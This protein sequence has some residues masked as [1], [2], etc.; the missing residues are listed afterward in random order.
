VSDYNAVES[1]FST[2]D[3]GTALSL[4]GW[5]AA[6]GQDQHSILLADAAA[7]SALFVNRAGGDYH[8]VV[9]SA[10]ID[11]GT[12]VGAPATDF[13]GQPRPS[14]AGYDIGADE[15][16]PPPPPVGSPPAN[17]PPT[18][19]ALPAMTV[20]YNGTSAPLAFRVGDAETPAPALTVTVSS[21]N[22][23]L[24]PT[25][26]LLLGGSGADRTITLVPARKKFGTAVITL[27]VTDAD[28]VS[29]TTSFVV[30][31]AKPQK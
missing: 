24:F 8:L 21:S 10:A 3:G 9:G 20:P 6:T 23:T 16:S 14:G 7:L 30:T 29:T 5:Q 25:S 31:V 13:E 4:V 15:F 1:R 22:P 28:G 11:R 12:A 2:D 18:I 26:G 19:S 27:T 17:N